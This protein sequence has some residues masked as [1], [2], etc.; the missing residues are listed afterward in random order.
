MAPFST[1]RQET[2]KKPEKTPN[3]PVSDWPKYEEEICFK[4]PLVHNN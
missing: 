2:K 1:R 3:I 4:I